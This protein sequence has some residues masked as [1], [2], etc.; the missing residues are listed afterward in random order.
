MLTK[1]FPVNQNIKKKKERM[2]E[3]LF[4]LVVYNSFY[5]D[6]KSNINFDLIHK[7]TLS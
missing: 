7:Y 6:K 2:Y 1:N 3:D 5:E 4:D